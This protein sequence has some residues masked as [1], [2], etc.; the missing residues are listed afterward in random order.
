M[1]EID[2]TKLQG[3]TTSESGNTG[4]D[5]Q[6][7]DPVSAI[8]EM[9][10]NTVPKDKYEKLQK[11][12]KNLFKAYANGERDESQPA[13]QPVDLEKL[14]RETFF[15]ELNNLDYCKNVLKIREEIMERGG[16]DPFVP[17]GSKIVA[18]DED[19]IAAARVAEG[20]Q[21][22]IDYA[23]GDSE[24]FTNELQRITVDTS[25]FKGANNIRRR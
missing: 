2:V 15:G 14:K 7:F 25:P 3:Q 24:V 17:H 1:P 12:Y 18:T 19:Y 9:K 13:P 4:I 11:D 22:C 20:L 10:A 21:A 23:E 8:N 16:D 5:E 6:E